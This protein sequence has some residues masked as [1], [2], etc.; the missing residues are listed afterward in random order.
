MPWY[1]QSGAFQHR[2]AVNHQL[3]W[4]FARGDGELPLRKAGENATRNRRNLANVGYVDADSAPAE[5]SRPLDLVH[6]LSKGGSMRNRL[7]AG[8]SLLALF[9]LVG[10]WIDLGEH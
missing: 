5:D 1:K 9:A 7:L 8:A 3:R 2:A 6:F 4:P 10:S